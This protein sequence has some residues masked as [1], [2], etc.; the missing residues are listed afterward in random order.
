MQISQ[1]THMHRDTNN[2]P[3]AHT[4]WPP[5]KRDCRGVSIVINLL[6]LLKKQKIYI[7]SEMKRCNGAKVSFH[8][9]LKIEEP[10]GEETWDRQMYLS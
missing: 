6:P 1:I 8:I 10:Q 2:H 3:S 7:T 4:D 5:I 9:H